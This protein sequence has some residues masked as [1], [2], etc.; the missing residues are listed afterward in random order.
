MMRRWRNCSNDR[1]TRRLIAPGD[2]AF[3]VPISSS[4]EART[5]AAIVAV[6]RHPWQEKP[7]TLVCRAVVED[8]KDLLVAIGCYH[9]YH[10][11][12]Q[13]EMPFRTLTAHI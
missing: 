8:E 6:V 4:V 1:R 2:L 12:S 9:S 11:V 13:T 5:I 10:W 3:A 7:S